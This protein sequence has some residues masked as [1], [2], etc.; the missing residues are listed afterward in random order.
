MGRFFPLYIGEGGRFWRNDFEP[1]GPT[2]Y[3]AGRAAFSRQGSF[4]HRGVGGFHLIEKSEAL[5]GDMVAEGNIICIGLK[6]QDLK[7]QLA[8]LDMRQLGNLFNDLSETH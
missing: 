4:P 3:P 2:A 7:K 1:Q 5:A 6:T 8:T